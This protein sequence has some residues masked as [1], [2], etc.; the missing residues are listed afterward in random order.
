MRYMT[1][2]V[3]FFL[4]GF[5]AVAQEPAAKT[6]ASVELQNGE[7]PSQALVRDGYT[8]QSYLTL[9]LDQ[10]LTK[11]LSESRARRLAPGTKLYF[12]VGTAPTEQEVAEF[13][14]PE[15]MPMQVGSKVEASQAPSTESAAVA[16]GRV[17]NQL[18]H[19]AAKKMEK[20][21]A[22]DY[23][24][25]WNV[26]SFNRPPKVAGQVPTNA[27]PAPSPSAPPEPPQQNNSPFF[28]LG[29]LVLLLALMKLAPAQLAKTGTYPGR[30]KPAMFE[31]GLVPKWFSHLSPPKFPYKAID[32]SK[33]KIKPG[34]DPQ[35]E[36]W[37]N[38]LQFSSFFGE[39]VRAQ[40]PRF[41]I[42]SLEQDGT[43]LRGYLIVPNGDGIQ[44]MVDECGQ[45]VDS[46]AREHNLRYKVIDHEPLP[47]GTERRW[48]IVFTD[49]RLL[50]YRRN[51]SPKGNLF[52]WQEAVTA[53]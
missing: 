43:V 3:A 41:K 50:E 45:Q 53:V 4:C 17:I 22:A 34:F 9:Y 8:A 5:L 29:L 35:M 21:S 10:D 47:E 18:E 2:L 6:I 44:E 23:Q 20:E 11:H 27:L 49:L 46:L 25:D 16:P 38:V 7:A 30:E 42:H 28:G 51:P 32:V 15:N 52:V 1:L 39:D 31:K 19:Q 36:H 48:E 13:G 26:P 40:K 14:T 12:R 37:K 33:V 24:R